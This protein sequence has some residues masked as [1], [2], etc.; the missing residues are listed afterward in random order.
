MHVT[1]TRQASLIKA[2][3]MIRLCHDSAG[4][5]S[6]SSSGATIAAF[7]SSIIRVSDKWF[8]VRELNISRVAAVKA[9]KRPSESRLPLS[10]H[11]HPSN[12]LRHNSAA[13]EPVSKV[14]D[15]FNPMQHVTD[16]RPARF[17]FTSL[18]SENSVIVQR[19]DGTVPAFEI[20]PRV[21]KSCEVLIPP[22]H[23]VRQWYL[24]DSG[25][26]YDHG[27]FR[28]KQAQN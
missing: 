28:V 19:V 9:P 16:N 26:R 6:N 11:T 21:E 18:L 7:R 22:R 4:M 27:V 25:F 8:R 10:F 5:R 2:E 12:A 3:S 17:A 23:C 14:C 13:H 15:V 20:D 24:D 1:I